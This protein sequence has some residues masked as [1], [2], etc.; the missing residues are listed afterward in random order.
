MLAA[1]APRYG[2]DADTYHKGFASGRD[3]LNGKSYYGKELP[4]GPAFGGPL[5]FAHY[6]FL[7]LDP[8]GLEDRYAD[9]WV[10]RSV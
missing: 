3:F 4:L 6:S 5:F 10:A 2:I 8:R 1:S 9:Y 7:G